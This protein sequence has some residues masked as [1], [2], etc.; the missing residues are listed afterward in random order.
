MSQGVYPPRKKSLAIVDI[1]AS[2][3]I[4]DLWV[5]FFVVIEDIEEISSD[6]KGVFLVSTEFK[7]V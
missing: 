7:H 5:H 1:D 4:I 3:G 2:K 6:R